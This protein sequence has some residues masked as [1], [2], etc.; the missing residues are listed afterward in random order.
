MTSLVQQALKQCPSSKIV[1]SG[2][3]QGGFVVHSSASS[4]ASTPPLG[5]KAFQL[6]RASPALTYPACTKLTCDHDLAVIFGD[7]DNG[8]AVSNVPASKL[9]EYCAT[10][11]DVCSGTPR[12]Y[13]ITPAHLTYGS[14]ASDAANFIASLL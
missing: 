3:S 7:P 12:T 14:D 5:G 8:Q 6:L 2:Y 11:D 1:L 13:Q 4:L 10:G 9:K